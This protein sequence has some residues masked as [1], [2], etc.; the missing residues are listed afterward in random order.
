[1]LPSSLTSLNN[2]HINLLPQALKS[3]FK[4]TVNPLG[5]LVVWL[6]PALSYRLVNYFFSIL[7]SKFNLYHTKHSTIVMPW[8]DI[9]ENVLKMFI[10]VLTHDLSMLLSKTP[11]KHPKIFVFRGYKVGILVSK[12]LFMITLIYT[13]E[14]IHLSGWD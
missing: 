8:R 9:A 10:F 13:R 7:I 6:H 11:W 14:F 5:H 2:E 4:L 1:M 12:G 3:F